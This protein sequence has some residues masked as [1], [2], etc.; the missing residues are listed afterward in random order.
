M[1]Y[2]PNERIYKFLKKETKKYV[3]SEELIHQMRLMRDFKTLGTIK[4]GEMPYEINWKRNEK[5][6]IQRS[7]HK[8]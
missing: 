1:T 5:P 4:I 8:Q 7:E 3:E 2:K 6:R